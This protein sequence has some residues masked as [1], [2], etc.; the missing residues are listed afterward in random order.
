M[1]DGSEAG[2]E[3]EDSTIQQMMRALEDTEHEQVND[4]QFIS[5]K[6]KERGEMPESGKTPE[7]TE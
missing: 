6:G 3:E 2:D 4:R 5:E 1:Q 7:N